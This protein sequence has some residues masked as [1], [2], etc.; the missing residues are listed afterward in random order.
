VT[1]TWDEA[2]AEARAAL[3]SEWNVPAEGTGAAIRALRSALDVLERHAREWEAAGWPD[4]G[5][6]ADPT[7]ALRAVQGDSAKQAAAAVELYEAGDADAAVETF[8]GALQGLIHPDL[9][10]L[11]ASTLRVSG[12]YDTARQVMRAAVAVRPDDETRRRQ[13]ATYD[14]AGPPEEEED[15]TAEWL[16]PERRPKPSPEFMM[17]S[18]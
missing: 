14:G 6:P 4:I 18:R 1:A 16:D 2:A 12:G 13:L 11:I 9:L 15:V 5:A 3:T 7:A 10:P 17:D 8:R